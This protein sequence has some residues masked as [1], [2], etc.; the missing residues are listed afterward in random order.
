MKGFLSKLNLRGRKQNDDDSD[1]KTPKKK[2][3]DDDAADENNQHQQQ[4]TKEEATKNCTK[5]PRETSARDRTK[6][7]QR[8]SDI[9]FGEWE[10][11]FTPE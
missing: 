9:R 3:S 4:Q 5:N 11:A 6:R 2:S 10:H 7:E 8:A 1:E